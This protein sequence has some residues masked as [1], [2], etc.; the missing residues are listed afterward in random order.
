MT[1][2]TLVRLGVLLVWFIALG[3]LAPGVGAM[4][5]AQASVWSGEYFNNVNLSGSPVLVRG[6]PAINFFWP[7]YTSPAPGIVPVDNYSVRWTCSVYFD[8][9]GNWYFNTVND[10]GMR[11][12]VDNNITM[13]AWYDQGPTAHVGSIYLT[14]GW[15]LVRVEYYNRTLGGT[16]RVS[17]AREGSISEWKGE[18]FTNQDLAGTPTLT[19]N[20]STIN[21]D[22]GLGSPDGSIPIDHFSVR[23]TRALYFNAGTWRFTTTTDDGVRLWVDGALII[24]KWINQ[25][26]TSYAADVALTA[27]NHDVRMEYYDNQLYA[28]A[29]LAYSIVGTPPT[30]TCYGQYFNNA[31]LSGSPVVVRYDNAVNFDWGYGS[32]AAGIPVDYFSA[33]W[34]CIQTLAT[35]GNYVVSATS[36]DCVRVWIDGTLV[37]DG[38]WDH[39]ATNFTTTRYL[40]AGAH[41][42]HVEFYERTVTASVIVQITPGGAPPPPPPPP[43]GDVLI[44]DGGPGWQAGGSAGTWRSAPVG[45]GNHSFWTFNNTYKVTPYNWA[46]WY[47]TLP[48]ARYYEVF[49]YIPA[50]VGNTLN[51][52]YWIY[53]GGRYDLAPRSQGFYANQWVSLGTYYFTAT[54]GEFVSLADV[55]YECYL[56]RTLV[57]D[58]V[59]FSPR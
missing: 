51:A 21:F 35:T 34:D 17:Y 53:H 47:P 37:I 38:W 45:I 12:W 6:D 46:R 43:V 1:R 22:W 56:C 59:K 44:D 39:S 42:V 16:A 2:L 3:V 28:V 36:D 23:W 9:T 7:E 11:I 55:T 49:V 26:V 41:N 27:G 18:Y 52:R 13:D 15:H 57:F 10:D 5:V 40:T 48:Q 25:P 8:T 24:D 33:K 29:K 32:P 20:D 14:A 4:P 54:G 19:R 31:T 30:G 58:A 50:G